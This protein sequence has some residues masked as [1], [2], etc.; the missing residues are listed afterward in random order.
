MADVSEA[1]AHR[2]VSQINQYNRCAYAYKLSRIDNVWQRPAAW[3]P[4]GSAVHEAAEAYERSGRTMSIEEAQDVFRA[5]YAEH[6][7]TYC[8]SA[9]NFDSWFK[10]GPYGGELDI[11]RRFDIGLE[12][13]AKYVR[14]YEDHPNEVIWIAPD[15]QP[16]IELGFDI[17]LDGVKVRGFIDAVVD[18][19]G[20]LVVRDNK[21]GNHPGD[22]FQLAVYAVALAEQFGI[23]KPEYGDYWMGRTGKPTL[24]FVLTDWT[25]EKVSDRFAELEANIQ[26]GNFEASPEPSKCRFCDV[27]WACEFSTT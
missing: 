14:W 19:D 3:L 27:S 26:A 8:E 17:D 24:P 23:N 15:G 21:T 11:E 25:R 4:Q 9:P 1:V 10:S 5:S 7:N 20:V 22:D 12:Q 2:S 16:G 13:V 18:V 6:V